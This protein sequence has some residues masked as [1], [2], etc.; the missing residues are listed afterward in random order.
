MGN[1]PVAPGPEKETELRESLHRRWGEAA[2]FI[3]E[4]DIF[5]LCTGAG[6]SADSGLA[7]YADV[8]KVPAYAL[9]NLAYHDICQPHWL[10]REPELFWGFWGQ[11][12]NDYRAT[13]PH[14]GYEIINKWADR[15]F[16]T[17]ATAKSIQKILAE[18]PR[19]PSED[20]P[21][22]VSNHAGAFFVFTSNVDAHHF[23]WFRACE[24]RE[25]HGNTEIYQCADRRAKSCRKVWRAPL[26]FKFNIDRENVLAPADEP[27]AAP[28][29]FE[30]ASAAEDDAEEKAAPSEETAEGGGEV[31]V[32]G[33]AP[34]IGHVRGGG[35]PTMLRHMPGTESSEAAGSGWANHPKCIQCGGA[36]RPAI[37]MFGD[38]GWIDV[39]SQLRRW[40]AWQHAA[41]RCIESA[42]DRHLEDSSKYEP[43]KVAILEVGAGGN[44]TTVRSTAEQSLECFRDAG[45]EARLIRVNPDLPLGDDD[46]HKPGGQFEHQILSLMSRGL[47]SIRGIDA[48]MQGKS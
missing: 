11:C 26:D 47:E 28:D 4:A 24:I 3:S 43:L 7:V 19:E 27:A 23:D 16:R 18:Q 40:N 33:Q 5:L 38:H 22:V 37:L 13:G 46:D 30:W 6:F 34:R 31:S 48:A 8:A 35:R 14:E 20:E 9:R 29:G 10:E 44:V 17:S 42:R 15:K 36:A 1:G 2:R 21:Y 32:D 25:C 41:I 39:E 45:A 12:Y